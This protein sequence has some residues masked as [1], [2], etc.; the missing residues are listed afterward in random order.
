VSGDVAENCS[1]YLA[2]VYV[3][4]LLLY[5]DSLSVCPCLNELGCEC[6]DLLM[7]EM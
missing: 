3:L 7:C 4:A 5:S 1:R 2:S 6:I